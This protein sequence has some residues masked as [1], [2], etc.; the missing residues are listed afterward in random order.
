M[1]L[2]IIYGTPAV[3]KYTVAKELSKLTEYRLLHNHLSLD[4]VSSV[5]DYNNKNFWKT[6][7]DVREIVLRDALKEV[8]V[9][10][11]TCYTRGDSD[12]FI[13]RLIKIAK[14]CKAQVY[15]INLYC[16][17]KEL[18]KR[19]KED[20]RKKFGKLRSVQKLR[21]NLRNYGAK[22]SIPFVKSLRIDN[23]NLSA[24]KTAELIKKY[25][26]L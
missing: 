1:K 18:F 8:S 14:S 23:T 21:K 15:F 3:G 2:V 19:V 4:L 9:I 25:Y 22:D 10:L 6:V 7:G 13:K 16:N 5:L 24:K 26:K 11:T 20:S 12:P 17:E